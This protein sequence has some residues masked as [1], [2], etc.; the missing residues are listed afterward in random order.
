MSNDLDHEVSIRELQGAVTVD[1]IKPVM[2]TYAKLQMVKADAKYNKTAKPYLET[3]EA[4]YRNQLK[5]LYETAKEAFPNDT[6]IN[7][8]YAL[9]SIG[10]EEILMYYDFKLTIMPKA[11]EKF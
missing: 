4:Q 11:E 10:P 6:R 9:S 8:D 7:P 5:F 2:N 3:V 1:F